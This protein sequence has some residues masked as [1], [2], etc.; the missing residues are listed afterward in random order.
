MSPLP[1]SRELGHCESVAIC[2]IPGNP[3]LA[4]KSP[5]LLGRGLALQIA[6]A[7]NISHRRVPV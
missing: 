4:Y 1:T 6:N 2:N 5:A 7:S 3:A